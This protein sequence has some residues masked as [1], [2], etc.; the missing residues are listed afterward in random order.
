M[1]NQAI[2][3]T[4][5]DSLGD[6]LKDLKAALDLHFAGAVSGVHIL[7]LFPSSAD[8]GFAPTTYR[9]VDPAFG[10]WDD[11]KAIARD[12]PLM[13]DFMINHIS[14]QSPCYQDFLAKKD[15]SP[16]RDLFILYR[17]FW[18]GGEPTP[19]QVDAIYKRKPRAPYVEAKFPDGSVEKVWCTFSDE[20]IDLDC[21]SEGGRRF[22]RDN[23]KFLA[24]KGVAMI[25]LD[26]FAYA[27][28]RV[29]GSC[30][31][32]EPGVWDLLQDCAGTLA[33]YGTEILPEIHEHYTIQQK[34]TNH[35]YPVYDFA[36]PMLLLNAIYF[37]RVEYLAHWL[38]ICPRRLYTTLDTHDGIGVVDVRGLMPDEEIEKT[39]DHLFDYG[40]NVKRVYN[41]AA[42]NNLDIYQVNCTYYS[43]LGEDDGKYLLARA[44]QVFAPGIPQVYYVGLLA[45]RNDLDL[46]ERTRTGRDINRHRYSLDEVAKET[47]RPVVKK[48]L[49][50][51]RFRN[52]CKAFDGDFTVD[53]FGPGEIALRW[54]NGEETAAL[55]ADF[56]NASFDILHQGIKVQIG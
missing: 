34:L 36:L 6:N 54:R 41:T 35:G 32:E 40:A 1:K 51:L 8:R 33:P 9:E 5:P 56:R 50:L 25:R 43:A 49:A 26:A 53:T 16:Y 38:T 44:V 55:R 22:I 28:K 2:L 27:I 14:A 12:Y 15:A 19:A 45:G 3:I 46:L 21:E 30:F 39:K 52:A 37:G 24:E 23:L 7:P 13:L 17:D 4:Y 48:L 31:F 11:V 47:G 42:Y 18:P 10:A 29:G 20:Q